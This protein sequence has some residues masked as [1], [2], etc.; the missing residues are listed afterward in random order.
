[1]LHFREQNHVAGFEVFRAPGTGDEVDALGRAAREDDFL[2]AAGV[3]EFG[4]ARPRGFEAG[5]GAVA[6]FVDAAMDVGVVVFVVMD[7]AR[8]S[9][10][11]A[12]AIVAAL[13]K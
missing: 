5:G 6:Q 12:S 7:A 11:A 4:G 2:G 8:Q 13:S 10:R 1:M 3:D 9:P